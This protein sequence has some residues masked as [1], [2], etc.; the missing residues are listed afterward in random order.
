MIVSF[1]K[2]RYPI[3]GWFENKKPFNTTFG[4]KEFQEQLEKLG[5]D[6]ASMPIEWRPELETISQKR[7]HLQK[8]RPDHELNQ[9]YSIV[10]GLFHFYKNA[11]SD[12]IEINNYTFSELS[13][14]EL[15]S[16]NLMHPHEIPTLYFSA[17][18]KYRDYILKGNQPIRWNTYYQ[19]LEFQNPSDNLTGDKTEGFLE[20]ITLDQIE[21]E[22]A[23]AESKMVNTTV[24]HKHFDAFIF[25]LHDKII[26]QEQRLHF[27]ED[28]FEIQDINEWSK[29]I[30][31]EIHQHLTAKFKNQYIGVIVVLEKC[32]Y[33]DSKEIQKPIGT[34]RDIDP[35]VGL[36]EDHFRMLNLKFKDTKIVSNFKPKDL[37][38]DIKNDLLTKPSRYKDQ[39]EWRLVVIPLK[40]TTK[41][42]GYLLNSG[43]D[44]E[45]M[46]K[47]LSSSAIRLIENFG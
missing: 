22:G 47:N 16:L 20:Q 26:S 43:G 23:K 38:T 41:S 1:V 12:K 17:P 32:H 13:S 28:T 42:M 45:F 2:E 4:W 40:A 3:V 14:D 21:V 24:S 7:N 15:Y 33:S 29:A 11:L 35:E 44:H 18:K 27:G 6:I 39:S 9:T 5:I 46:A 10:D 31:T 8:G 34:L 30:I 25:S 37:I 36:T 19:D